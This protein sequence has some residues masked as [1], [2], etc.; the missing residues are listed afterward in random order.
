MKASVCLF[1]MLYN[2]FEWLNV[3]CRVVDVLGK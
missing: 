3:Y 1:I 2:E